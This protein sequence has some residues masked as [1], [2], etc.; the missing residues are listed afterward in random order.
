MNQHDVA[1]LR[2]NVSRELGAQQRPE[3]PGIP[4]RSMPPQK[5]VVIS[6]QQVDI[7]PDSL[8]EPLIDCAAKASVAAI[9]HSYLKSVIAAEIR[10]QRREILDGVG[11]DHGQPE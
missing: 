11:V 6:A 3:S 9:Q 1:C 7:P 8:T 10:V 2:R 4:S 5:Y